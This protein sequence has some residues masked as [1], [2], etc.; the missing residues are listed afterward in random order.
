MHQ[1]DDPRT[2]SAS[3]R[4]HRLIRPPT[5]ALLG[6]LAA[7]LAA[8]GQGGAPTQAS[9]PASATA[10][11]PSQP[12]GLAPAGLAP[13]NASFTAAQS[14]ALLQ[15]LTQ[16]PNQG[17]APGAFGD[18]QQ[19]AGLLASTDPA[20]AT[21]AQKQLRTAIIKYARAQHGLGLPTDQ[22]PKEWGIRPARYDAELDLRAAQGANH[23]EGWLKSLPPPAPRYQPLVKA[24]ASYRAIAQ[25]G[26]WP[27]LTAHGSLKPGDRGKRVKALKAR[28]A[29]EDPSAASAAPKGVFDDA[30]AQAVTRFQ[31]S[32]QLPTTGQVGPKTWLALNVPVETRIDQIRANL[33]R[34]RWLPRDPPA[35]RIEVDSASDTMDFYQDGKDVLHMLAVGG[36]PDDQTPMLI[37]KITDIEF[38]PPWRIPADIAEKELFPKQRHDHGYFAREEIVRGPSKA[39]PL[40]QKAGPKS[41]LGQVKFEFDNAYGVYLHDTPAKA[42]FDLN[43][44]DVSHGCVR[45]ER[46]LDLAKLLLNGVPGWSPAQIDQLVATDNTQRVNLP[47]P[48]PVML[49]Y[50]TSYVQDGHA[51]FG[52]D[53]YGWDDIVVR[54]L[55]AEGSSP[56]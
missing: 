8:C 28:L 42:A 27:T 7:G 52:S 40:V 6:L 45:L 43:E 33:E 47:Q 55:D 21:T 4:R 5:I 23:I 39:V 18:L 2:P 11:A 17:F 1:F 50:W 46:A 22:F 16:S 56:A 20:Q 10:A 26:G 15:A 12:A 24:L 49:F 34:W 35:T 44:R 14:Q 32:H 25:Q 54:L 48:L 29:I 53:P 19:L 3:A 41:A 38:N 36:K 9:P 31:A 30:M 37:S 51:V 13:A